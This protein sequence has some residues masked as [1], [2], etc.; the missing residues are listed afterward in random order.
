MSAGLLCPRRRHAEIPV[1]AKACLGARRGPGR[2]QFSAIS[3]R[4]GRHTQVEVLYAPFVARQHASAGGVARGR[5]LVRGAGVRGDGRGREAHT[6]ELRVYLLAG[7]AV[8]YRA[9]ALAVEYVAG[10]NRLIEKFH[11]LP[12]E[13]GGGAARR[14][15]VERGAGAEV[16]ELARAVGAAHRGERAEEHGPGAYEAKVSHIV[17]EAVLYSRCL[18]SELGF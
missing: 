5:K 16:G 15:A 9:R 11:S 8:A 17:V 10:H 3:A 13:L 1:A 12:A 7:L 4:H 14:D 18:L 6:L 2:A